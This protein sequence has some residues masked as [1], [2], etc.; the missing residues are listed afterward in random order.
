MYFF[1][2]F[3]RWISDSP[4]WL[5]RQNKIE[6]ALQLLLESAAF[7]NREIPLDLEE[8]LKAYSR[9]LQQNARPIKYWHIWTKKELRKY[10][11]AIHWAWAIATILYN[12]MI[13]MIRSLGVK[14]I[15]VNSACLGRIEI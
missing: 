6:K 14:H 3:L 13:L 8:Q 2:S 9:C 5:L 1:F 7:N 10:I 4:R 12:V 15:H 11:I